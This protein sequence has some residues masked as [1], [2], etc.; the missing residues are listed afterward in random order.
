MI[1]AVIADIHGNDIAFEAVLRD[2]RAQG[3]EGYLLGGDYFLSQPLAKEVTARMQGLPNALAVCGNEENHLKTCDPR[4]KTDGQMQALYWACEQLTPQDKAYLSSLPHLIETE[5]AGVKLRMSHSSGEFIADSEHRE[6]GSRR[7]SEKYPVGPVP[8]ERFL[9]DV[10]GTLLQDPTFLQR[11]QAQEEGVTLFGHSHVQW[12]LEVEGRLF[13]NP[14]SCGMPLDI[15]NPG[16][17]PYTLL[18]LKEGGWRVEERRVPYDLNQLLERF[19]T[20]GLS[21]KAPVWSA[22]TKAVLQTGREQISP[23]LYFTKDYAE[24]KGDPIR[25][26]TVETWEEAYQAWCDA[27]TLHPHFPFSPL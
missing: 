8:R 16:E 2:A 21:K 13:L 15:G 20:T 10:Q 1:Y 3:A 12:H 25:P 11:V 7:V 9:A 24:K 4:G 19:D 17:A 26:Y 23:F 27:P 18:E 5:L 14:G 22:L 6:Y